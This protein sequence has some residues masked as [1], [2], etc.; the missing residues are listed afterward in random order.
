MQE[1]V[2]RKVAEMRRQRNKKDKEISM[3]LLKCLQQTGIEI[4]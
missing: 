1:Y 4:D 2:D 3:R